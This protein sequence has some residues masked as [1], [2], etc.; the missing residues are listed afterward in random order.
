MKNSNGLNKGE[1]SELYAFLYLLKK[2]NLV[3]V[4]EKLNVIDSKTFKVI[5]I[6][7]SDKKY[8]VSSKEIQKI[9]NSDSRIIKKYSIKYIEK[10]INLLLEKILNHKKAKGSF[11]INEVN[12]LIKDLLDGKKFKGHSFKKTDLSANVYDSKI[13]TFKNLSYNIKS[14][15]GKKATLLNASNNT[16]FIYSLKNINDKILEKNNS[17]KTRTKLLDRI[18]Y[19]KKIGAKISFINTE[20][21][22]FKYNLSLIDS[23]LHKILAN[24][25]LLSYKKNEKDI[26]KLLDIVSINADNRLFYGKKLSDFVSAVTF[27]MR[28]G[29]KWDGVNK[30]KGGLILVT[31]RGDV[32]L[33]DLIYFEE[34]VHKYLI[35]NIKLDSPSSSRYKMLEIYKQDNQYFFKL[36]LQIRFK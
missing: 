11:E 17:I 32:Y 12:S 20:S 29:K 36:N 3:I 22:T 28:A 4:D 9:A 15:L 18:Q 33:L 35:N 10:N 27:G 19:L 16:N 30:A 26:K 21:K 2:P 24:M 1:W 34:L 6:L 8:H 13:G 14:N 31:E 25:L 23:S 7:L 5:D